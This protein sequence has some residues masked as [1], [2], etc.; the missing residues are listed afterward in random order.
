MEVRHHQR[1]LDSRGSCDW[2]PFAG[3]GRAVGGIEPPDLQVR[4]FLPVE[5]Q[6]LHSLK[7]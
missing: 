6:I 5:Q 4:E 3:P 7:P 1:L 2:V